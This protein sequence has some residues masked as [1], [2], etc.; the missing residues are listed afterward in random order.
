MTPHGPAPSSGKRRCIPRA[1][2]LPA[3]FEYFMMTHVAEVVALPLLCFVLSL[4]APE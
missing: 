2:H 3:P 1:E 4:L